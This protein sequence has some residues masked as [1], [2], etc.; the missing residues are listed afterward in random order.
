MVIIKKAANSKSFK[1]Y[2]VSMFGALS[3]AHLCEGKIDVVIQCQNKIWDVHAVIPIIS[4]TG[5][6]VQLGTIEM[7]N[8]LEIFCFCK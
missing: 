4:A 2:A 3:Y 8:M 1:T 5:E 7:Q 6:L